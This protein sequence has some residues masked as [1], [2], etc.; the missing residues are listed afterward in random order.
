MST[1]VRAGL[2]LSFMQGTVECRIELAYGF[3]NTA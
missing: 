1:L 3:R 2:S